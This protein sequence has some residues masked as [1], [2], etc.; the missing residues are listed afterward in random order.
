MKTDPNWLRL[1]SILVF[2]SACA[3]EPTEGIEDEPD[4]IDDVDDI[5]SPS[6]DLDADSG[7]AEDTQSPDD[8]TDP[9][10]AETIAYNFDDS[11]SLLYVQ[12]W[13][14]EEAWGSGWAHDHVIRAT[15]WEGSVLYNTDDLGQCALSFTVPVDDLIAD[16]SSMR[17]YVGI[18][19]TVSSSDRDTI[20]EHMLSSDQLNSDRY[21]EIEFNSTSCSSTSGGNG[22]IEIAGS[23][24]L[25][26]ETK[27]I[28]A[29][30]DLNIQG[31]KLY[32]S[33]DLDISATQFGF[34]PYSA[35]AGAVRNMDEMVIGLDLVGIAQ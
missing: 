31:G 23:L 10:P 21:S 16:E 32:L 25:R 2:L 8:S 18:E 1:S 27:S 26:G 14:D 15:D 12:V 20:K 33:G 17:E 29:T 3:V 19:G 30:M 34:E 7:W 6:D 13:K 9:E 4:T 35:Y 28:T 5:P 24:T 11:Q 22:Q